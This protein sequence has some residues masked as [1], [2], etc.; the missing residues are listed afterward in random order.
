MKMEIARAKLDGN[1]RR[2]DLHHAPRACSHGDRRRRRAHLLDDQGRGDRPC[3]P[4]R[5]RRRSELHHRHQRQ[6]RLLCRRGGRRQPRLLDAK[7]SARSAAP[8]STAPGVD[9]S[10]IATMNAGTTNY[11]GSL[12]VDGEPHLLDD[13]HTRGETQLARSAAPTSTARAST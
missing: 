11:A 3:Q 8:T 1:E 6:L 10:F 2:R 4:R 5:H 12:A 7:R 13:D 9:Q